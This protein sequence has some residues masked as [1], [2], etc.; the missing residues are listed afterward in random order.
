[1]GEESLSLDSGIELPDDN[2]QFDT[3]TYVAA[4]AF[5]EAA[6]LPRDM[7]EWLKAMIHGQAETVRQ[8]A[9]LDPLTLARLP[10]REAE[11]ER[12]KAGDDYAADQLAMIT[13]QIERERWATTQHSFAG[14]TMTGAEWRTVADELKD[15]GAGREWLMEYLLRQGRTEEQAKEEADDMELAARGMSELEADRTDEEREAMRR[16]ESDPQ[17]REVFQRYLDQRA[18]GFENTASNELS[19]GH[20]GNAATVDDGAD[21]LAGGITTPFDL[22]DHHRAAVAATE[23]LNNLPPLSAIVAPQPQKAAGLDI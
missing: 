23:P 20:T 14:A 2:R 13:A 19:S 5:N 7:P 22:T 12:K 10:Q 18:R 3:S 1:M 9:A 21:A 8:A 16:I 17:K 6:S 11:A 15:G 4:L